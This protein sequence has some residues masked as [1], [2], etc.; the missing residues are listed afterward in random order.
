MKWIFFCL[1]LMISLAACAGANS[2]TGG[3][4]SDGQEEICVKV[5]AQEPIIFR[6]PIDIVITATST[7]DITGLGI[8][9]ITSPHTI[10]VG[11]AE[12]E[13]EGIE[14]W[15]SNSGIDWSVNINAGEIVTLTRKIYLPEELGAYQLIVHASTPQLRAIDSIYIYQTS[16]DVN[17]YLSG[18]Q[19]PFTPS[20][21]NDMSPNELQTLNALTSP[22]PLR[23]LAPHPTL[24]STPTATSPVYPPPASP[25]SVWD[26]P[27]YPPYP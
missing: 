1:L 13:E 27:V 19:I 4:S 14:L 5:R 23:T 10:V 16:N 18:T 17:I 25:T 7:R 3:C 26:A 8:S 20:H 6:E 15:K 12:G 9:L 24:S 2:D 21:L 11:E 22:T